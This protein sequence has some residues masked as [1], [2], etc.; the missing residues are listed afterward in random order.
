MRSNP[1]AQGAAQ[2]HAATRSIITVHGTCVKSRAFGS[3]SKGA[4]GSITRLCQRAAQAGC[5]MSGLLPIAMPKVE[6]PQKRSDFQDSYQLLGD[7]F[8]RCALDGRAQRQHCVIPTQTRIVQRHVA[9]WTDPAIRNRAPLSAYP[10][11]PP[12][13][14]L[15]DFPMDRSAPPHLRRLQ[16]SSAR[17]GRFLSTS[18]DIAQ[19]DVDLHP[20]GTAPCQAQI[21]GR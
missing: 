1:R 19:V 21:S 5:V 10:Q 2:I 20:V 7:V 17:S 9:A 3:N 16:H 4:P 8:P 6:A 11:N 15:V 12:S 18:K 14:A 13:G